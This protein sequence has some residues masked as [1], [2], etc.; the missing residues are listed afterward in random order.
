MANQKIQFYLSGAPNQ[1]KHLLQ[2]PGPTASKVSHRKMPSLYLK[3]N[4]MANSPAVANSRQSSVERGVTSMSKDVNNRSNSRIIGLQ[5]VT[6]NNSLVTGTNLPLGVSDRPPST[7]SKRVPSQVNFKGTGTSFK[8]EREQQLMRI[9]SQSPSIIVNQSNQYSGVHQLVKSKKSSQQA[10][11]DKNSNT[12]SVERLKKTFDTA[13][14]ASNVVQD[15]KEFAKE[16]QSSTNIT[17]DHETTILWRDD[18]KVNVETELTFTSCLGQGSFAKVYEGQDKR[19]AMAV[20]IK[21]IDKRKVTE[22]KRRN[23]IQ[24]E[25]SILA[26]MKHKN[27]GEFYRLI[28]DHKR[29]FIVMQ[30]CGTLTLNHFCRQFSGKRLN[31]EQAYAVFSQIC[32]G[33]RYM[34]DQNVAHRDLK[35][36]NILIDEEYTVKIID[37]GFACEANERHKMYCG[38][39]S[40]MAPE[41]VEKKLYFPKPTDIW[42][43]GVVLFKLLTG[44]YSFGGRRMS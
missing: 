9:T 24:Q 13:T 10:L 28:E 1:D 22:P 41:I 32:K 26:R 21:V 18:L 30:L 12:S 19:N 43:L 33:V 35:L 27:I 39:P 38:T 16:H 37:F 44:E 23:L 25:I 15:D 20:A 42:S 31:E 4:Y 34:H 29:L 3:S 6:L 17:T 14:K 2:S 11:L 8:V 40:Y 7:S 36:T 5:N